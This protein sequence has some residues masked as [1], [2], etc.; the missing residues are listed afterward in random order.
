MLNSFGAGGV[1]ACVVLQEYQAPALA[2]I[3][4]D[5]GPQLVVL[6]AKNEQRLQ[7]IVEQLLAHLAKEPT[8]DLAALVYTLQTGREAMPQRLALVVPDVNALATQL[9]LQSTC[10]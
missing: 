4:V 3:I 9:S 8:V 1:N 2:D 7:A 10:H 5:K 6:S